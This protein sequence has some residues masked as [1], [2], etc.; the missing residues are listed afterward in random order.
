[1]D[2]GPGTP[3][4]DL[5][6]R[7]QVDR[8]IR[9]VAAQGEI[10]LREEERRALLEMLCDDSDAEVAQQAAATLMAMNQASPAAAPEKPEPAVERQTVSALQRIAALSPG[11]RLALAMKGTRE[12]RAILIRD[13][14]KMVA[15]AVLSSPKITE[16]E[17]EGIAKMA[18]VS[19]DV[20]R[21]I[22][23]TRAWAKNYAVV[24]ALA[25][26]P[27]TPVAVSLTM[28]GRL[29]EK[30]IKALTT[31]RNIPEVVRLAARKRLAPK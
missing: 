31:D 14:N 2:T 13:A 12:E 11:K 28:L 16:S 26:N 22:G 17:V 20:L 19:E 29:H 10:G 21:I 30:E 27:K 24:A 15:A 3:F 6:R 8:E 9:M 5:F 7:S 25:R 23:Q 1:M 4:L 18:N